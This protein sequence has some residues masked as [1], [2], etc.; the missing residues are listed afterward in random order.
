M[1]KILLLICL[2][3][4]NIYNPYSVLSSLI[5]NALILFF[6][7]FKG[8]FTNRLT[9]IQKKAILLSF[10][11]F[12]WS[13][14]VSVVNNNFDAYVL[15]KFFRVFVSSGFLCFIL[16]NFDFKRKQ[17]IT[18][19]IFSLLLNTIVVYIQHYFPG[20]KELFMPVS[21][22]V[23][24]IGEFRSFGLFS[25]YD[26]TGLITC[27][28][29]LVLWSNYMLNKS[30]LN[31]IL[32]FLTF[33][34][35]VYISRVSMLMAVLVFLISARQFYIQRGM[36][37]VKYFIFSPVL[38]YAGYKIGMLIYNLVLS[39]LDKSK[40]SEINYSYST[41]SFD[42]L[43]NEMIFFPDNIFSFL[44]GEGINMK[45][46]DIGYIKIIFMIGFLG[47]LMITFYY[48]RLFQLFRI[49]YIKYRLGELEVFK[50]DYLLLLNVLIL[51]FLFNSKLL[52]LYSRGFNEL[53]L[54]LLLSNE[55][56]IKNYSS[57]DYTKNFF[58]SRN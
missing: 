1:A 10:G 17:L 48:F 50:R 32:Y 14:I 20:T 34:S 30:V 6:I 16:N 18:A 47:L 36:F 5:V 25:S 3:S 38:L 54:I 37:F 49:K 57:L 29:M 2:I 42:I 56:F 51:M 4:L 41:N 44:I 15:G 11:I 46:S 19:L 58:K 31:L 24:K 40:V 35:T 55:K 12:L 33:F 21:G 27:V 23:K 9:K 52:L 53:F 8:G 28:L 7:S 43:L 26:S 45:Y 39:S 22:F 13:L